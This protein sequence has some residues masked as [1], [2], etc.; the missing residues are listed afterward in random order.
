MKDGQDAGLEQLR[1]GLAWHYKQYQREQSRADRSAYTEVEQE[2]QRAQAGLWREPAPV[3][4]WAWRLERR[5]KHT[6]RRD[7]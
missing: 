3:A 4:P 6:I 2:A 7:P 5:A 1:A